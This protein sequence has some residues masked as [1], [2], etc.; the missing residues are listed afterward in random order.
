MD[1]VIRQAQPTDYDRVSAIFREAS[2]SNEG[3]RP[4]LHAHPELLVFD[5]AVLEA[6]STLVAETGGQVVGFVTIVVDGD[7]GEVDDLFVDPT[8]MRHGVATRMMTDAVAV[9][10]AA[11]ATTIEVDANDH[12]LAFYERAGFVAQREVALEYGR[13]LRMRLAD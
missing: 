1:L 11:G 13:A 7:H 12:A 6:G 2:L 10:R 3:D 5:P 9:A 8:W 4:L